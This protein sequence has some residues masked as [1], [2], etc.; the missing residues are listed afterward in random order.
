MNIFKKAFCRFV[1]FAF[2]LAIPF[3]PYKTPKILENS[4]DIVPILKEKNVK[5]ILFVV[6]NSARKY[7]LTESLEE[8]L[9][10]N[11]IE[12]IVY[13]KVKQNPTI[14]SIEEGV[15]L[16]N[17][18]NC[19]ALVAFGGG[20][21]IDCAKAIGARIAYP[22]KTIPM[23]KGTLKVL[24]KL[25][26]LIAIPTTAGSG[27]ETTVAAVV[28]DD[29]TSH[30]YTLNNFTMIPEYAVLDPKLT[31]TLPKHLTATTGLDALTHAVEA[32][33]GRSRTKSSKKDALEAAKLIF[34]NILIA[35]NEPNNYNARKN[36]LRASFLAGCAFTKSYVGYIHAIAHT[37]GGQYDTPHGLANSVIMPI[38]LKEYGSSVTKKL[39]K[40]AM[41]VGLADINDSYDEA[42]E[43]FIAGIVRLNEQMGI[44][45]TFDFIKEEDI[46]MMVNFA[47][48]EA[49]PLY[50]VPKLFG[51]K[52]LE[53]I[54]YLIK[55]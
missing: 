40:L 19:G 7:G 47:F 1:Q 35:Y 12:F 2:K 45:K 34:E 5:C 10:S 37:L 15:K 41:T 48:K 44:P 17:D 24:K 14:T 52:E 25:P 38:V 27:S 33:I 8:K 42:S 43:K 54:Y 11:G 39:A 20:S 31:Y 51:K 36:M 13:D 32:Y 53:K 49:N 55:S 16:Y 26:T 4:I 50:P 28:T 3:L 18:N 22:N 30:K 21:Q 29:K 6:S 46:K 23:L 9:K